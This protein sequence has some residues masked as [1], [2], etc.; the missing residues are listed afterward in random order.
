MRRAGFTLIELLVVIAVIG[1]LVSLLLPAVQQAREA[2]R[3]SSCKN[4][5]KQLGLAVHNYHDAHQSQ[6]RST[7]GFKLGS[8]ILRPPNCGVL[9]ALLPCLEQSVIFDKYDHD[10]FWN[11][12]VNLTL[13]EHRPSV[14]GCPSAPNERLEADYGGHPTRDYTG[15]SVVHF[16]TAQNA[17]LNAAWGAFGGSYCNKFRNYTDGLSNSILLYESAGLNHIRIRPD[18]NVILTDE[19]G[20]MNIDVVNRAWMGDGFSGQA[21]PSFYYIESDG[22][23]GAFNPGPVMNLSNEGMHPYSYHPGGV[24]VSMADGSVRFLSDSLDTGT[25]QRLWCIDD[26]LVVGEF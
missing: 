12:P 10:V 5:L 16:G 26:G 1:I 11:D 6:P 23:M 17:D 2:A 7:G 18:E 25:F 14:Y 9:V 15:G 24:Q 21:S 4:N 22:S 8:F 3:R 20:R 19:S 13:S